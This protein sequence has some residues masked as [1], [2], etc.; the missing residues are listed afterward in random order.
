MIGEKS[1]IGFS[2]LAFARPEG[3]LSCVQSIRE[4]A[5]S[6]PIVV[7]IDRFLGD[8]KYLALKNHETVEVASRLLEGGEIA[9]FFYSDS[10]LKT[11]AAWFWSMKNSFTYFDH[12]I[13]FEDDLRLVSTPINYLENYLSATEHGHQAFVATLFST[14]IHTKGDRT[15]DFS[16]WPELWGTILSEKIFL[17]FQNFCN[18]THSED[19]I[20]ESLARWGG[21]NLSPLGKA[22]KAKFFRFWAWKFQKAFLSTTAWDTLLHYF[23]WNQGIPIMIPRSELIQ[24]TGVDFTSVSKVKIVKEVRNC[25]YPFR[26]SLSKKRECCGCKMR[27]EFATISA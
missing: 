23:I 11:K 1:R 17:D 5:P 19:S 22:F 27:K 15:S 21:S 20:R 6:I 18:A 3:L 24:D 7:S 14:R 4:Y 13:Y 26:I 2:V 25:R 16:V 10:S 8:D 9:G 12:S